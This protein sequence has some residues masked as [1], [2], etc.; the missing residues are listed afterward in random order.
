MLSSAKDRLELKVPGVYRSPCECW[1][2]CVGQ[3]GRTIETRCKEHQRYIYLHQPERSPL[4]ERSTN[5][6][7][8][9]SILDR[10]SGYLQ[11]LVKEAT[12]IHLNRKTFYRD[13]GFILSQ[14]WSSITSMLPNKKQD[15]TEQVLDSAHQPSLSRH[16][17]WAKVSGTYIMTQ[18][19]IWVSQFP[20]DEDKDG[21]QNFRY[22]PFNHL[23]RL[24]AWDNFIE[25]SRQ[26]LQIM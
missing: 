24:L 5:M 6:G 25:L 18:T 19:D 23:T 1:K 7:Y 3:S 14:A 2:V 15:Q 22:P 26:E 20:D 11:H 4:T 13:C 8:C 9:T 16:Q 21:S 12:D 17:L 10:T